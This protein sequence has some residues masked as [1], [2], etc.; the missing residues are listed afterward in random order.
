MNRRAFLTAVAVAPVA[1]ALGIKMVM[2]GPPSPGNFYGV[3]VVQHI[4]DTQKA[5]DSLIGRH[6][7][8]WGRVPG[9]DGV[10]HVVIEENGRV[11]RNTPSPFQDGQAPYRLV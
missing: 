5:V 11:I 1:A 8:Y 9:E 10:R 6:Y 4:A 7:S 3:S 2:T